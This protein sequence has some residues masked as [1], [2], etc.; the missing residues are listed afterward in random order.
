MVSWY[1]AV[2]LEQTVHLAVATIGCQ[3][4]D[5]VFDVTRNDATVADD[6]SKGVSPPARPSA[7]GKLGGGQAALRVLP[8]HFTRPPRPAHYLDHPKAALTPLRR[9]PRGTRSRTP[10]TT[11]SPTTASPTPLPTTALEFGLLTEAH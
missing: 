3:L 7:T 5:Y 11:S 6:L 1:C 2:K 9:T 4:K 8:P 10:R